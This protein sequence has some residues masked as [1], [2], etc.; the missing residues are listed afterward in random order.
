VSR[1]SP[2]LKVS[3][4]EVFVEA[5]GQLRVLQGKGPA[6]QPAPRLAQERRRAATP[7]MQRT[8][9]GAVPIRRHRHIKDGF[10]VLPGMEILRLKASIGKGLFR[11][12]LQGK[13]GFHL[14][15]QGQ[16]RKA[17][18]ELGHPASGP[19]IPPAAPRPGEGPGGE[20]GEERLH[21][22]PLEAED[23]L[24]EGAAAEGHADPIHQPPLGDRGPQATLDLHVL[25][26]ETPG[27]DPEALA[28]PL[29]TAPPVHRLA[30]HRQ[31]GTDQRI[32][33]GLQ[34][35]VEMLVEHAQAPQAPIPPIDQREGDPEVPGGQ[36]R[37]RLLQDGRA[38]DQRMRAHPFIPVRAMPSMI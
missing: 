20:A 28:G 37:R 38:S 7:Q 8:R 16:K 27:G 6:F 23:D 25:G 1:Q 9:P 34:Q 35:A 26:P 10:Q 3:E 5:G 31:E 29:Q 24:P 13:G 15:A 32:P 17:G 21:P 2:W 18:L 19:R 36:E 14:P 11:G 4:E 33:L 22:S 30:V 12:D